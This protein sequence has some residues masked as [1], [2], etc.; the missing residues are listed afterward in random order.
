MKHFTDKFVADIPH[1][2]TAEENAYWSNNKAKASNKAISETI[3]FVRKS[4]HY[5]DV[6]EDDI[7]LF[8]GALKYNV[9]FGIGFK[10]S[11]SSMKYN[12]NCYCPFS[13]HMEPW[14]E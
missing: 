3:E 14:S 7:S 5:D 10:V 1:A 12:V 6:S 13:R 11:V 9:V 2:C 4:K 8:L